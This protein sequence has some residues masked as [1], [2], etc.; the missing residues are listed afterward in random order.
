VLAQVYHLID[1]SRERPAPAAS[2]RSCCSP[3][4]PSRWHPRCGIDFVKYEGTERR[5]GGAL[6]AGQA[7]PL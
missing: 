1:G 4:D 6:N 3:R 7:H 2:A 5:H